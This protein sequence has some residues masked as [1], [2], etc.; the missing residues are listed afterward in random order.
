MLSP[1]ALVIAL[2]AAT[3][4]VQ[5]PH[6]APPTLAMRWSA[7]EID[8]GEGDGCPGRAQVIER[9]AGQGVGERIG[10]WVPETH[11]QAELD[12]AVVITREA[13]D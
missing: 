5:R 7:P 11:A 6:G 13:D 8:A 2:V 4:P 9:I 1:L 3:P 12:V 10:G